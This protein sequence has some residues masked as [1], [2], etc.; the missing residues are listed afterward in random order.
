MATCF[1]VSLSAQCGYQMHKI[2][3]YKNRDHYA[4]LHSN[5]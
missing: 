5:I 1:I 2:K 3:K 4:G